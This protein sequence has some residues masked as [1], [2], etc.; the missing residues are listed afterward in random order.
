MQEYVVEISKYLINI[1]MVLYTLVSFWVLFYK[2]EQDRRGIYIVQNIFMVLVQV[3]C[4]L[5]LSLVSDDTQ[6][7]FFFAFILIFCVLIF[8][9]QSW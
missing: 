4:F 3:L 6:F 7:L 2:R 9:K 8:Q 1:L 5:N